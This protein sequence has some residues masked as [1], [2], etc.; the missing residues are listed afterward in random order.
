MSTPDVRPIASALLDAPTIK[1]FR[2]GT[3]RTRDPESTLAAL[4][5]LMSRIG[6][7]RLG[8]LTRLDD[9]GIPIYHAIRPSS[10]LSGVS[11]GKGL[12]PTLAKVSALMESVEIWHAENV[13]LP[14]TR[15]RLAEMAATLPYDIFQV[16]L[17]GRT[18]LHRDLVLDWIPAFA[19]TTVTPTFLP[20]ELVAFGAVRPRWRPP[21]FLTTSNGLASGNALAEALLHGLCEII[22]RD[23]AYQWRHASDRHQ[24]EV[25]GQSID[26]DSIRTILSDLA[27]GGMVTQIYYATRDI[28][29]PVFV[30]HVHATARP[31]F[32]VGYGCHPD[33]T[34][35]VSRAITE[36]AQ[37]R[38]GYMSGL[39]DDLAEMPACAYDDGVKRSEG[40]TLLDFRAIPSHS[41]DDCVSDCKTIIDC[42]ERVT[43]L[44]VVIADL[45]KTEVGIPVLKAVAPG[46]AP[47]EG[48]ANGQPHR[49]R[50]PVNPV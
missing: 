6:I 12:T 21:V 22:E 46:L 17:M 2:Y 50:R 9:V 29:V 31:Y 24:T 26:A 23:A 35:A 7:T 16:P 14:I 37:G 25:D 20:R 43:N 15:C 13:A 3:H 34:I 11:H 41:D 19:P 4:K 44:P 39:R 40:S 32:M 10:N 18:F 30:A 28:K 45:T 49:L 38:V 33:K 36:A 5:P 42:I 1:T 27:A 48:F 47:L 8:D